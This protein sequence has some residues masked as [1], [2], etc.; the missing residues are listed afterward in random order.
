MY[1]LA[2]ESSA[3]AASVAVTDGE[4]LLCQLYQD[5]GVTHSQTLLPMAQQ[6][7]SYCGLS[8]S[9]LGLVAVSRGPGSFTGLRIGIAT[10]KGLC[11]GAEKPCVGVSTLEAMAVQISHIDG[12]ICPVMDAR[13]NQFYN[14]VFLAQNGILTRLTEDRA[15]SAE[16]LG[17]ELKNYNIPK[18]LVGDGAVIC[19]NLL[20]NNGYGLLLP[21]AHLMMQTA[22]GVAALALTRADEAGSA[23]DLTPVYLRLSQAERERM[24]REKQ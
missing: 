20:N 5:C 19:Y 17:A 15:I 7:L 14:A 23:S 18:F 9:D 13:R 8:V 1:I 10:V 24:E 6:A 21:P 11:W 16:D 22:Y 3:K 12:I 2:L 4:K